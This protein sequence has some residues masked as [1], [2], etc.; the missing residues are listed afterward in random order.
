MIR[1][2]RLLLKAGAIALLCTGRPS[3]AQDIANPD[4]GSEAIA[5][6]D[7]AASVAALLGELKAAAPSRDVL[8][9]YVRLVDPVAAR[10]SPLTKV[11][12]RDGKI[13]AIGR[14]AVALRNSVVIDGHG[15]YLAP[16][17]V[18][19]HFHSH[20]PAAPLLN[21]AYGVT[22]VREMDGFAWM[23]HWRAAAQRRRMLAPYPYVAG[24]I[25][26][27]FDMG[28]YA[29]VPKSIA[30]ARAIVRRQAA[31]GFEFI[32]VHNVVP[33]PTFDA[34]AAEA[35][36]VGRPLVGHVPHDIPVRHAAAAGMRTME[37][38]K[39]WLNDRNLE[40]GDRDFQLPADF[41]SLWVVPTLY[42]THESLRGADARAIL[43]STEGAYIPPSTRTD[44][45]AMVDEAPN[46]VLI[47]RQAQ[48]PKM[49]N[50]VRALHEAGGRF[51]AG[52]DADGGPFMV[53]GYAL[54]EEMRLMMTA[55]LSAPE[56]LRSATSEAARAFRHDGEFGQIKPGMRGDLVLLPRSP[57]EDPLAYRENR[58]VMANGR[59]LNRPA[60]VAALAKVRQLFVSDANPATIDPVRLARDVKR[61]SAGGY[62]FDAASLANAATALRT[63]A[64][65]PAQQLKA[66]ADAENRCPLRS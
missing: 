60:L 51:L 53:A 33:R 36:A 61:L 22:S 56:V 2:N 9:R 1:S 66:L 35:K 45:G 6:L 17:L 26:N 59:W 4:A 63:T 11:Q 19:A 64:P 57:L 44:L 20:S 21:L 52:T 8:F 65:A 14:R 50:I 3:P 5:K 29:I 39:G 42:S 41:S 27:A 38:L 40:L 47:S 24:Q 23:L 13:V 16:G 48:L 37:H 58:G 18:D 25:I 54:T 43:N 28:G 34:I 49:L 12:V 10:A 32:K 7:Q 55:G 62:V 30:D 31:C 46:R 15:Q